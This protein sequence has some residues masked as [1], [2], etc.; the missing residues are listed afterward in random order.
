MAYGGNDQA[1]D[2][3][4][5]GTAR[6]RLDEQVQQALGWARGLGRF[7]KYDGA[8]RQD[9][10]LLPLAAIR[11]ALVNAVAHRD[12]AIIGSKVL[13]E[14]FYDRVVVTSPGTL[15]NRLTVD[16]VRTGG[17]TRSRNEPMANYMLECRLMEGAFSGGARGARPSH[18]RGHGWLAM[19][20]AMGE[21]NGTEPTLAQDEESR[22][23]PWLAP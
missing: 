23:E 15:P 14:V 18:A 13:L 1:A 9:I 21:F 2:V 8:C 7:E 10:P 16:V 19:R 4:L 22:L 6:G 11:E 3:I 17:R 12:Y 5:A 20:N